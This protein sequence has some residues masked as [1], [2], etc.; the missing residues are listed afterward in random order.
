MAERREGILVTSYIKSLI[1]KK[2]EIL[3]FF[4]F[5]FGH[6]RVQTSVPV[7]ETRFTFRESPVCSCREE[8]EV[9]EGREVVYRSVIP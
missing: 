9:E 4:D 8:Y 1:C 5:S 7:S 2:S 6:S 3:G